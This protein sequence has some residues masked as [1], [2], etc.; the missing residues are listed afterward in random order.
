MVLPDDFTHLSAAGI[1]D[2]IEPLVEQGRGLRHPA[3]YDLHR[4]SSY[5]HTPSSYTNTY[6]HIYTPSLS[7]YTHTL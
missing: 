3:S 2:V 6:I 1:E 5:T 7:G 4:S